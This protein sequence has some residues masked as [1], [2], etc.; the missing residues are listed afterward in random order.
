MIETEYLDGPFKYLKSHW[1]LSATD[2][3]CRAEFHV[4]FEMKNFFLQKAVGAVFDEAMRKIVG[5]FEARAKD[6]Y[7]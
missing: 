5:A 7:G 4:D 2:T 6:L 1:K 3:G